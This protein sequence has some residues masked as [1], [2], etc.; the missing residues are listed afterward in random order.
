MTTIKSEMRK[1]SKDHVCN[2]CY[3]TIRK[4]EVYKHSTNKADCGIYTWKS[5][6]KC[7]EL[8]GIIWDLVDPDDGM[9]G[10]EFCDK[11][12][13]VAGTFICPEC[14]YYDKDAD[15]C[16]C[17]LEMKCIDHIYEFFQKYNLV[18]T[19]PYVWKCVPKE[20]EATD[21]K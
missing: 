8:C 18:M 20:S 10:D 9:T 12:R 6:K 21:G 17:S 2:F 15:D 13:E 7:A 16:D 14:P 5:H 19:E 3:N 11:L 4:G 1:A